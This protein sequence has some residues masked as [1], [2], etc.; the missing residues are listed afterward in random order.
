MEKFGYNGKIARVDLSSGKITVEEKDWIFYRTYFGGRGII[1]YYLLRELDPSV[2]PLSADNKMVFA[3]SVI[4][5]APVPGFARQSIGAKSPQTGL[6]G[7]SEAGGYWGPELKS[8][9]YDAL[10]IEGASDHP[11]YLYIHDGEI[12][13]RRADDMW[14]KTTGETLDCLRAETGE[15]NVRF[16]GIGKAGENMVRYAGVCADLYHY[17][18]RTGLGAV[19]GSKKLKAVAVRGRNRLE[20][21]DKDKVKELFKW[22]AEASKKNVDNQSL[23][24]YGTSAYY[25]N[26]QQAGLLPTKNFSTTWF[27]TDH[28]VDKVHKDLKIKREGCYACPVQCKQ[29]F[30]LDEPFEVDPRYGGPEFE[31][32]GAFNSI[33]GVDEPRYV[34]KAHDL[35]NRH[36]LDTISCGV[37]IGWAMECYEKGILTTEDTGGLEPRFGDGDVMIELIELIAERKGFGD[38]LAEGS[39]I[40]AE[41]LGR[42]SE[43]YAMQVKGLEFPMAEPR[44]KFGLGLAYVASP[45]GAD[46]LQHE[47]DG[48]FDPELIGYSHNPDDPF[49]MVKHI[50]P[51][52][53]L[54]PIETLSIGWQKV[55]LV[56]YFQHFW[57]FFNCVDTCIF[58]WSPVRTWPINAMVDIIR[59]VTGWDTSLWEILKVGER[60]T[61]M[62]R[63]FNIKHGLDL[64]DDKL[65]ERMFESLP[66]GPMK[67][68]RIEKEE[69]ET[70]TSLYYGMMGWDEKTGVPT[71]GKLYELAVPWAGEGIIEGI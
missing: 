31:T 50:F 21:Y 3:T 17:H 48:A 44:V 53:I 68:V 60:A 69:M 28:T 57:S 62:T 13:I 33:C 65:P 37:T 49:G 1:A 71:R 32:F 59:G 45:T 61:N 10:V 5:G 4:T 46:H 58:T 7:E 27:D 26:A 70:A 24:E 66:E 41:K 29:S 67:N 6:F 18:G 23:H 12:E 56:T 25:F 14:G 64:A 34:A 42:G 2:D 8:A 9:G 40:A 38:L 20:M 36:G 19:M 52:G 16:L 39:K 30:S 54:E 11:V 15:K 55:R 63:C 43:K 51:L 35:C 47:H 22:F